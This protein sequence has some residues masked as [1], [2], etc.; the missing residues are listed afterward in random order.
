MRLG[1]RSTTALSLALGI[2]AAVLTSHGEPVRAAPADPA[3]ARWQLR[4]PTATL[5][6]AG[7]N[8]GRNK[9][10]GCT[11][12]Q[13]GGVERAARAKELLTRRADGALAAASLGGIMPPVS[14]SQRENDQNAL[15]AQFYRA[16]VRQD[17]Y[18]A[19]TLL[20]NDLYVKDMVA[21]F[22]GEGSS[23]IDRPRFPVNVKPSA[24]SGADP[25]ATG[26][27]WAEF[28]LRQIRIRVLSV[29]DEARGDE[30]KSA[31][32]ADYVS[33]PATV[34]QGLQPNADVVWVIAVDGDAGTLEA[35]RAAARALGPA[36]LVDMNSL[37]HDAPRE[38]VP[39]GPDPLVVSFDEKGKALGVLDFDPGPDGKGWL[40]S[41]HAQPLGPDF[42]EGPSDARQA[43]S[44]LFAIYRR[45]VREEGFLAREMRRKEAP[46]AARFVGSAA[47]ARC[48]SGIYEEWLRT[49]HAQALKT[50][51]Q[52]DYDW[53][54]ECLTCHVVG[55]TRESGRGWTWWESGFADAARTRHLGGVG[56]ESCHGPGSLHVA[57]PWKK[58]LF[59][60]GGPN[61]RHPQRDGCMSCHDLE[62]SVGFA[63]QYPAR[64]EKVD[65][66]DVPKERRI[67][68]PPAR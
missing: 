12:P 25:N 7:R 55:V 33:A 67:H 36:V 3:G 29:V 18:S 23:E 9:P 37:A 43:I 26:V 21:S 54:P 20:G 48:H 8:Q 1:P 27:P 31:G 11:Q 22:G 41:Y 5:L 30:L 58:D 44:D 10:C 57:E 19:L 45:Q 38:R 49:H 15:K 62:N 40:V 13:V 51:K 60:A 59:A 47:C 16:V 64:L 53:D 6:L 34:L 32:I 28:A 63:E 65:H 17:D 46:G 50:L 66:R 39:L 56:C 2:V 4:R 24:V 42:D 14:G 68:E 52:K 35:V 61:R